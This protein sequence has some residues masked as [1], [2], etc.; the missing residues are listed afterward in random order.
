MC[1]MT[2]L[3]VCYNAFTCVSWPAHYDWLF[4]FFSALIAVVQVSFVTQKSPIPTPKRRIHAQM[5]HNLRNMTDSSYLRICFMTHSVYIWLILYSYEY[6]DSFYIWVPWLIVP[7]A[8]GKDMPHVNVCHD[9]M[10]HMPGLI[11]SCAMTHSFVWRDSYIRVTWLIY[12]CDMM[13]WCAWQNSSYAWHDA[14]IRVTWLIHMCPMTHLH[15]CHDSFIRAPWLIHMCVT[16]LIHTCD[17]THPCA[18]HD[19]IISVTRFI[20]TCDILVHTCDRLIRTCDIL[21]HTCALT[22]SHVCCDSFTCVPWF[23][24]MC[25]MT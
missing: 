5:C 18:R 23:I 21:I 13:H 3:F 1:A 2:H 22:A 17:M 10:T 16:W 11:H 19:S 14:F 15:I 20:H 25:A 9:S 6:H 24:R 12:R 8:Q 7:W 4:L